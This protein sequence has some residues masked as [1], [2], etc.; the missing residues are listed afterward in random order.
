MRESVQSRR[1]EDDKEGGIVPGIALDILVD[2][3]PGLSRRG[4]ERVRVAGPNKPISPGRRWGGEVEG[5]E[6]GKGVESEE[7]EQGEDMGEENAGDGKGWGGDGGG[8]GGGRV[9]DCG[10]SGGSTVVEDFEIAGV[11]KPWLE[12]GFGDAEG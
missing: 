7:G 8:G 2:P 9:R 4:R 1:E 5:G 3:Q 10:G 6:L 11:A 12:G